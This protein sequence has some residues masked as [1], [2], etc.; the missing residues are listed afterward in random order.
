M[1]LA[2][3]TF[4]VIAEPIENLTL[5]QAIAIAERMHPDIAEA[6]ALVQAAEA[7]ARQA[8]SRPNPELIGRVEAA[9]FS[10][11]TLGQADYLSGAAQTVP[12]GRRLS[13]ARRVENLQRDRWIV[14][15]ES[16]RLEVHR[17]VHS[18]FATALYQEQ[19]ARTQSTLMED[20]ERTVA[21][22]RA[23]IDAGDTTPE[24]LA[25]AELES[26]RVRREWQRSLAW[27]EQ[28]LASL[29]ATLGQPGTRIASLSGELETT[30]EIP[31]LEWIANDLAQHPAIAEARADVAAYRARVDLAQAS[32]IPDIRVE[33]L[34]RRMESS[35][36]DAFDLGVSVPLPLFDR[37]QGRIRAAQAESEAAEA[38]SRSIVVAL[39]QRLRESHSRLKAALL[40][41]QSL[42][43]DVLPRMTAVLHAYEARFAAGDIALLELLTVRRESAELRME[44]L[45]A[46]RGSFEAWGDLRS[47]ISKQGTSSLD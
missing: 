47:L 25:R 27:H 20:A 29:A 3:A 22:A 6:R 41:V 33:A 5:L 11:N 14:A 10:G 12:L 40:D 8:G 30:L 2:V 23:R 21:L 38:R 34:Y 24:L 26:A 17:L 36:K 19:A 4:E 1:L 32:R 39:E 44:Y 28:A 35:R 31:T 43:A 7:Q 46:L 37:N 42:R 9:P 13:E 45:E 16:R 18:A 15:I